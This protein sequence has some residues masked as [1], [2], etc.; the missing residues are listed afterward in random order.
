[1]PKMIV[2]KSKF[3]IFFLLFLIRE[4][5]LMVTITPDAKR[6]VVLRSGTWKGLIVIILIGGQ[7]VPTSKLGERL[8]WKKAQ[9]KEKKNKISEIIN[10]I[11]PHR[12][13]FTTMFVWYPCSALSRDTSRHHWAEINNIII[14]LTIKKIGVFLHI[15][16]I[17][18]V[19]VEYVITPIKKGQGLRKTMWNGWFCFI[20]NFGKVYCY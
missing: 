14:I 13:P 3:F 19:R 1:M 18:L 2:S 4:W 9:K 20:I 15:R 16:I 6:A 11:M 10:N 12:R 7:I 8:L 17:I 5:W